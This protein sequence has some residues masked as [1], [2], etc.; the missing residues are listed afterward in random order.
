MALIDLVKLDAMSDEVIVAKFCSEHVNELRIGTQMVV[1]PSQEALLVKGGIALDIFYPG[2]HT[3]VTG[4]IPLLRRVVNSVF[5]DRTPFTAEVWFINKT[6]KRNLPWGTPKRI[7]VMDPQFQFPVNIGAFGQWG[8]RISDSR[9]FVTQIVG[10]QLGADSN[11]ILSYFIGEIIEKLSRNIAVM[12]LDGTSVTSLATRLPELSAATMGD[13][14][15]EFARFGVELVNFTVASINIAQEEMRKIQEV[16]AKRMEMNVLGATPVGQGYV[17]AKSFEIMKD[18]AQNPSVAG[19]MMAAGA[20]IGFGLGATLPAA[21][22]IAHS[23]SVE[24]TPAAQPPPPAAQDPAAK[25]QKLK[26][27]LESGLIT[28]EEFAAKKA[29]ILDSI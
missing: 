20:G 22:Q 18:A 6:V 17:T 24:R 4:N 19:G 23:M 29:Q 26:Y 15:T 11:K 25:L 21:Q 8:F 16:M 5:G 14:R 2:T 7:P 10:S 12:V 3:I 1:N 9:S 27:M 13:I 28:P